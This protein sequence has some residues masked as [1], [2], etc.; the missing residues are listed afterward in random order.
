MFEITGDDIAALNDEDLR[1]LVGRLCETE[2]RRR[3]LSLSAVTWGGNQTA[4]DGGLDVRV[5]L[6]LG[7]NINGFVPKSHTGFQVR[8]SDMPRAAIIHEMKPNG[9]LRPV[10]LELVEASGA[11][12]IVSSAGSTSDLAL[13]SRRAAM[14]EA[15]EGVPGALNLTLDFYD[16]NRVATWVRD[17]IGMIPWVR[18]RIGKSIPGW[19]S[20]GSW[21]HIPEGADP[22]YIVDDAAR[23]KTG[24]EAE[25][26]GVSATEGINKIRDVLRSPGGMVRLVGLSGVGKTRL[27]EAL[28]DPA[29][30]TNSLDRSLALYTDVAEGPNPQPAG[31]ASDLIAGGARAILI[32]D[33]CPPETHR[34]LSEIA[35][36]V[37]STVSV[38]TIEYDIREDQAEGTDVFVLHTS[39]LPLIEKLV[40]NRRPGLSR[41][42]ARTIAEFSGGNARIALTLAGT[43]ETHE[44]V[45][46]L[47]DEELFQRLFQQRHGHDTSLLLIAQACSL[48]YS[49]E[50]EDITSD[51]TELSILAAL[52]GKSPEEV[53][54]AVAELKRRD[55][56]QARGPWRAVLPHA[57]AN[58]LAA[59]A[60]QNVSA[61]TLKISFIEK[62]SGRLLRSFSRRLGYLDGSPEAQAIVRSWL[63]VG[64]F[65]TPVTDLNEL[66][67]A[68]FANVAPVLPSVVLSALEIALGD[69]DEITLRRCTHFVPL[70]RSLAY[71]AALFGR[72]V[73][74]LVKFA[75]LSRE[76]GPNEEASKILDSL[77]GIV[78]SGTHAPLELRLATVDKLLRSDDPCVRNLGARSLQAMC[79]TDGFI[80]P[81]QFEFGAR[82]RDYGC[83]PKTN[84]DLLRWFAA[85]LKLAEPFALSDGG[86]AEPARRAIAREFR[87]LWMNSGASDDL[88]QLSRRIGARR[89]WRDGWIAARQTR[90]Y[91]AGGL[92]PEAVLRLKALEEFLR[93]KGLLDKIRGV[94]LGSR[95]GGL[96][97]DDFDDV[98]NEDYEG[99][100]VRANAA[101]E[102]LGCDA[103]G[104]AETFSA[105]L[106]ELMIDGYKVVTFGRG[107]AFAAE[108]PVEVW[109]AMVATVAATTKPGIGLLCGFL[110]GIQKKDAALV[111]LMLD[112]ALHDATLSYWFPL[113][114]ARVVIDEKGLARL[115]GALES[116][117][118]PVSHFVALAY[119]RAC[120]VI[121][122]PEFKRLVLAIG[123]K[124]DGM[125]IALEIL[126]MRLHAQRSGRRNPEPE[127]T[128]VSRSLLSS[129]RFHR[130]DDQGGTQDYKLGEIIKASLANEEGRSIARLMCRNLL[131]A[132]SRHEV[133][134]YDYSYLMAALFEVQPIGLLDELFSGS[135]ESQQ[136]SS[137][138]IG[139]L[140]R[141]GIN[142]MDAVPDDIAIEWCD[143]DPGRRYQLMAA[144]ANLFKSPRD[145]PE[146]WKPF[147]HRLLAKAPHPEAVLNEIISRLWPTSWT[148]SLATRLET[149]LKLLEQLDV[150]TLPVLVNAKD[151]ARARWG[152][153]VEEERQ[154]EATQDRGHSGRFE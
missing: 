131:E 89:F 38:I 18:S 93:P 105:L 52:V 113:L 99:A 88:E 95:G 134:A 50:G 130:E 26:D 43:V 85:V 28:F 118:A 145:A 13:R 150:G 5:A 104:D 35:R 30:G 36:S 31:L 69:A 51:R 142:P 94:V 57:V 66:G 126:S 110:E 72:S 101:I 96:E 74:L 76:D 112:E 92:S 61:S 15:L 138:L 98:K 117:V 103:A 97:P 78:L 102:Y 54:R 115:H 81:Y 86:A 27:A 137:R 65:L 63:A 48:V 34:R 24:H 120:D 6:G 108:K 3:S 109:K 82:S 133:S 141:P 111:D 9:V 56:L 40:L 46:G 87:G 19:R 80:S 25:G 4:K 49:F 32:I 60:L 33:N 77:F 20:D 100:E 139:D 114:Q 75:C 10:I 79:K 154:R 140:R 37:G 71:D 53:F 121:S 7:T 123:S 83:H 39:S 122:G 106:P 67:R 146:E 45:A 73:D 143:Q 152:Q 70:L 84:G 16:R 64:G 135:Q 14:A 59:A 149:R 128:E 136:A 129:Y 91:G 153:L 119:G 2:L 55:L 151:N 62:A 17:H 41:V 47:N 68:M 125:A 58:R 22:A 90:T 1:T 124:T 11:Y 21:S 8:K 147:T 29:I 42:D 23:V 116:S 127:I 132:V 144:V 107:V 12:V 148:G 44:T